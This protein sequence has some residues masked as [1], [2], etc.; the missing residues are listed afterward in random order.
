L[1]IPFEIAKKMFIEGD[2]QAGMQAFMAGQIQVEGDMSVIMQIQAVPPSPE[3]IELGK[4][5]S[6]ITD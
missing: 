4:K 2:Q 5:I 6:A 1:K 3:Q